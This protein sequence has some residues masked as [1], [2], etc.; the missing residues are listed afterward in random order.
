VSRRGLA[1]VLLACSATSA[2][3]AQ[4][5]P[6]PVSLIVVGRWLD[7]DVIGQPACREIQEGE[8]CLSLNVIADVRLSAVQTL[9]GPPVPRRLTA[10]F[11]FHA[12]PAEGSY[13]VL[14]VRPSAVDRGRF[15]GFSLGRVRHDR[16]VCASRA[17]LAANR[18]PL[19][20]RPRVVGDRICFRRFS[21]QQLLD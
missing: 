19:P 8:E 21:Q 7:V 2:P 10:R 9:A 6:Q 16:R 11:E 13:E 12:M 20:R 14:L 3:A 1:A 15:D 17:L 5:P 18:V 4:A